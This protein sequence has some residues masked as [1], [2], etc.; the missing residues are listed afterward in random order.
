MDQPDD[1][2]VDFAFGLSRTL[3]DIAAFIESRAS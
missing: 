3:D 2:V 1:A